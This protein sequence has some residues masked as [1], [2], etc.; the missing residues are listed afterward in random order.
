MQCFS[1]RQHLTFLHKNPVKYF[2][3]FFSLNS[4]VKDNMMSSASH[5]QVVSS[6]I[7]LGH[8]LGLEVVA[9][10]VEDI[11]TY[12]CLKALGCDVIQGYFVG[13]A[14]P[15]KALMSKV[16]LWSNTQK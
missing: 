5:E 7:N 3:Q 14:L 6:M 4:Y 10:G 15:V 1:T 9:E 11:E 16:D 13:S 2:L 12:E 8:Y